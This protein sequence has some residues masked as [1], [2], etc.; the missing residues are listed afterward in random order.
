MINAKC[1]EGLCRAADIE[2]ADI[3]YEL[4]WFASPIQVKAALNGKLRNLEG[5]VDCRGASPRRSR[6]ARS[7]DPAQ[8][9][10]R[11]H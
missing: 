1:V 6:P 7:P 4:C 10:V 9:P 2:F 11:L 8:T 3:V 5:L